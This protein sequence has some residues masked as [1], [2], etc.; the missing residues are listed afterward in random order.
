LVLLPSLSL[1]SKT[2]R[3]W[4]WTDSADFTILNVTESHRQR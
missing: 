3:E 2:M 1:L 4:A